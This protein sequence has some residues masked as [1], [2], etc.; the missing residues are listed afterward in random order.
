MRVCVDIQSAVTQRAGVG[1]YTRRLT[2]HLGATAGIDELA[3]FYFDFQRRGT[4][5]TVSN[6]RLPTRKGAHGLFM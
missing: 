4:P 3:L 2:E 1:R 6:A 5:Y